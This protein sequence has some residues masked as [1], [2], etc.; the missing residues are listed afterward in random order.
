MKENKLMKRVISSLL[1][2]LMIFSILSDKTLARVMEDEAITAPTYLAME[3]E[4]GQILMGKNYEKKLAVASMS[5]LMT[6]Y[7]VKKS[8]QD[9]RY[10]LEDKVKITKES[11]KL[12]TDG[13]SNM[14]LKAGEVLRVDELLKGMMVVSGND[15]AVALAINDAKN[16]KNFARKMNKM[17]EELKLDKSSFVNASGIPLANDN[18]NMMSPMDLLTLAR[19]IVKEYPEVKQYANIKVLSMPKR[20]FRKESTLLS[21]GDIPGMMGLKT[22]LTR[23]AGYCFAGYFD[24]SKF[25]S[26]KDFEILTVVMG[27]MS[28]AQRAKESKKLVKKVANN[29]SRKLLLNTDL[30]LEKVKNGKLSPKEIKF[31]PK[32]KFY[33][34]VANSDKVKKE[35]KL[36]YPK[37]H[38]LVQGEDYGDVILTVSNEEIGRVDITVKNNHDSASFMDRVQSFFGNIFHYLGLM[39]FN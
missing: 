23:R 31:Y 17:A 26:T 12:T 38:K 34:I 13:Y 10:K 9:G 35:V 8:I 4:S 22:G 1:V 37:N 24:L 19:A 21:L 20:N 29:F 6:Y 11:E 7:L 30:V 14:G 39:I 28:E 2:F 15:A 32:D 33:A 18:Q 27:T 36:D 25:D 5:K 16:E 3:V